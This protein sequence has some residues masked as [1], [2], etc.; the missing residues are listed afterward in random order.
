MAARLSPSRSRR[1]MRGFS[2]PLPL[3]S[4]KGGSRWQSGGPPYIDCFV[5]CRPVPFTK[6]IRLTTAQLT[7]PCKRD[8]CAKRKSERISRFRY[9][10][11]KSSAADGPAIPASS[12]P[13]PGTTWYSQFSGTPRRCCFRLCGREIE[14]CP[15]EPRAPLGFGLGE[16]C[17][18]AVVFVRVAPAGH[19][20][21]FP[22]KQLRKVA[23]V[24]GRVFQAERVRDCVY[25]GNR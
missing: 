2:R 19:Y 16:I 25:T 21:E 4:P 1:T 20:D 8:R 22:G 7:D 24:C 12:C 18:A 6:S 13:T 9:V 5:V 3:L 10:P 23:L 15:L 17:E 11:L 14:L